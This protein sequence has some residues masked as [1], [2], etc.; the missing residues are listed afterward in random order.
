M[1]STSRFTAAPGPAHRLAVHRP[2]VSPRWLSAGWAT[3]AGITALAY[4]G[5]EPAALDPAAA[6]IPGMS[7][8]VAWALVA[9]ALTVGAILPPNPGAVGRVGRAARAVGITA[10]AAML[11]AWAATYLFDTIMGDG[12]RMW[13]SGKNYAALAVAAAASAAHIARNRPRKEDAPR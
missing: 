9:L 3:W 12:G 4:V 7:L 8:A 1:I 13:V 11:A 6:L 5:V 10:L 2:R